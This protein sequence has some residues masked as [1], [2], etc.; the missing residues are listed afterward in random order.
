MRVFW[1]HGYEGATL[2]TLTAAMGINRPSMYAAFGNK[3]ALFRKTLDRYLERPSA[4]FVEALKEPK[5]QLVVDALFKGAI[6]NYCNSRNPRGCLL[7][8]SALACSN[9][10]DSVRKELVARRHSGE[11]LLRKRFELA[12]TDDDLPPTADPADLARFVA[13]IL[14]GM[15]VQSANGAS[16][17]ELERVAR[18]A[19]NSVPGAKR[20]TR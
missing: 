6:D 5:A 20:S 3:E 7:I 15:S 1:K 17:A 8:Q 16:R 18:M 2:P 4:Y 11:A 14:A 12:I 19:R 13:T 10:S 9:E